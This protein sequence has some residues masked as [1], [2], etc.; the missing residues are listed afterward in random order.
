MVTTTQS[1]RIHCAPD[2]EHSRAGDVLDM[3]ERVGVALDPWQV[4][5]IEGGCKLADETG[6]WAALEVGI[7]VP[8]QNGKGVIL[9]LVEITSLFEWGSELVIHSAHEAITSRVHFD[10]LWGLVE[11]TPDL[12]RQVHKQRPS[13][14]HGQEGFKL[15]DGREILF[16]TRTKVGGRGL[17]CDHL[18][19]DEAMILPD[20]ALAAL[21]PSL[22]AKPNPQV[23]YAGSAVDQAVHEHGLVF[24]RL[25]ERARQGQ[26]SLAYFEWS[27][28]YDDPE[29]IP[30]E[31]FSDEDA[32]RQATP[33]FNIRIS[34]EHFERELDALPRRTFAVELLGVGD[35]P[36][37]NATG[38][39]PISPDA[40]GE[41]ESPDS[42]LED[43]V[44]IA[45]DV[46]PG[47]RA[48]LA[49]A[50]RNQDGDWH[51]EVI[52]KLPGTDWLAERL[53]G[54]A[55]EHDP[56]EIVCDDVGPGKSLVTAIEAR[57]VRVRTVS[58]SEHAEAC[59]RLV[60]AVAQRSLRH[61][62]S[63]DLWNAIRGAGT[64]PLGD[65]WAWSRKSST[66]DIS[67]LVAATLALWSAQEQIGDSYEGPVIY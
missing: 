66:V 38:D 2:S 51:V 7:N 30:E 19:L 39:M 14:S 11:R 67:P 60:D 5:V 24:T 18:F 42:K 65:R 8:R 32:W 45:F 58:A 44:C 43:P 33:A 57:G 15:T 12:L 37:P 28:D 16:R 9:E 53:A 41:C 59:G 3:A 25:R 62:G 13:Y 35:Y 48:A 29:Q 49:A 64:R 20:P 47:R 36:D 34:P 50:G 46:S 61:R 26:P 10:R 56:L 63:L 6:K 17:S 52:E 55:L 31:V 21:F 4:E 40:W 27:L 22:R 1:A 23:W 54:I